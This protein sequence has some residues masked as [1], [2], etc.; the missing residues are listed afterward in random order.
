MCNEMAKPYGKES[1]SARILW[2]V[3]T[4]NAA[5]SRFADETV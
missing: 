1:P 4:V 3:E 2:D 5:L